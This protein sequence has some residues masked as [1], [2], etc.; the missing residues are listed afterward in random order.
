MNFAAFAF[1]PGEAISGAAVASDWITGLAA[2]KAIARRAA[3]YLGTSIFLIRLT[4][5]PVLLLLALTALVWREAWKVGGV[6]RESG[7][8]SKHT[9]AAVCAPLHTKSVHCSNLAQK[10]EHDDNQ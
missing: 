6:K 5:A 8:C 2:A 9:R 4:A 3:K 7:C 10:Q 1:A